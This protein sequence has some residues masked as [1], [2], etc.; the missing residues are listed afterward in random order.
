MDRYRWMLKGYLAASERAEI[1]Q[2]AVTHFHADHSANLRWLRDEFQ[3]EVH[4][5]EQGVPL[6]QDR[7]PEQGLH[8]LQDNDVL[9]AGAARLSVIHTPGHSVDSVCFYLEDEGVLF[10]GDTILGSTSTSVSDLADYMASLERL[11]SL[12][13]LELICPGHGPIIDEPLAWIDEYIEH[14]T[15]RERQ[16]LEVLAAADA[17]T[18]WQIMERIY[19]D[20][21]PRLRR[22]ADGN[23]RSHLRK[24]EKEGRLRVHP[25]TPR[26]ASPEETAE[27]KAQRR[28]REEVMRRA[29][30]YREEERRRRLFLQEN[31][32]SEEWREP[33]RYE[34]A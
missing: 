22:A 8:L 3:A 34:L 20:L 4:V 21:N 31:P 9:D 7:L 10:S 14:R 24:L 2:S 30:Q 18:S 13:K 19:T 1:A 17:L 26:E 5:L 32:P 16:I 23:V 27:A 29:E 33:P 28:E 12:P 6:M 15:Q 25:G 11:R